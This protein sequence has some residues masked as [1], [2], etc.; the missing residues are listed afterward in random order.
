MRIPI[1]VAR[2]VI[3]EGEARD[4]AYGEIIAGAVCREYGRPD[5]APELPPWPDEGPTLPLDQEK[6]GTLANP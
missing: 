1:E 4:A 2:L 3:A 5:L 6:G